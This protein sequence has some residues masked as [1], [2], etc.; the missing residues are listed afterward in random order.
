[1]SSLLQDLNQEQKT[2]VTHGNGPLLLVAG[3]GTGKTTVITKRIAWL[4]EQE[5]AKPEEILALT[6][7]DKAAGE[8][9]ERIDKLLPYGYV[10][11]WVSTFHSFCERILKAHALDIGIPNDFKLLNQV[12][13]WLVIRQNLDRFNLDYY[14][15][16]GNPTKFIHALVKHFSRAK[17]EEVTT[18]EYLSYA[19]ELKLNAGLVDGPKPKAKKKKKDGIVIDPAEAMR[20]AEVA[21][22]Y[23]VYQQV[24]LQHNALDFGDLI[25]YALKLFRTRPNILKHYQ[26]QFKYILVDEFQDT[27]YAQYELVKMLAS[28]GNIT[29]VGDDDQSIYKFRGAS[30]SN[31]LNFKK[32]YP[33][34]KEVYLTTNYRS[35]Q[36]ILDSAYRFIQLNNPNRLEAILSK[37]ANA[38]SKQLIAARKGQGIVETLPS[39]T[40][41]EETHSI[42]QKIVDLKATSQELSWSDFAI[43]VRANDTAQPFITALQANGIPYQWLAS[44]GLYLK[45][46]VLDLVSYLR[47]L[48]NYHE[49]T[50]M[51]RVLTWQVWDIPTK[52]IIQLNH[53]AY[54]KGW[55]VYEAVK[56]HRSYISVDQTVSMK[57]DNIL[58]NVEKHTQLARDKK[59]GIVFLTALQDTG[60]LKYLAD[61]ETVDNQQ[62]AREDLDYLRQFYRRIQRFEEESTVGTVKNFL[63][64]FEYEVESGEEGTLAVSAEDPSAGPDSVKVMTVHAAKGLEFKHVFLPALVDKR[65][66]TIERKDPIELPDALVKDIVPEGDVH[67]QEERRLLY[68]AMTRARDGLYLSYAKDYGGIRAKKPSRF[69]EELGL[70]EREKVGRE[71]ADELQLPLPVVTKQ[72]LASR[73]VSVRLS[74]TQLKAYENC[75]LQYKF[76]HVLKIP[77]FGKAV[78]S[79]GKTMHSTVQKFMELVNERAGTSQG[80]LFGEH[81]KTKGPAAALD[82]LF[83]IYQESWIDDW[84]ENKKTQEEYKEKGK[85]ALEMFY[86]DWLKEKPKVLFIEKGFSLKVGEY[87]IKGMMDRVDEGSDGSWT[88]VDYKTGRSKE[89]NK[90]DKDQLYIYQLAVETVF[91]GKVKGLMFYYLEDGKKL[92][93]L[94]EEKDLEKVKNYIMEMGEKI[95]Q[96]DFIPTP[97]PQVCKYCDF[98]DICEF[99]K[100]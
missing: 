8:M 66:P 18:E 39:Q 45:S 43:L 70:V 6:F 88:I 61:K 63:E 56:Q 59:A 13:Q 1:M 60:Y 89:E 25:G 72:E 46:V 21:D 12:E 24:M 76:A 11:L 26:E 34:A 27:N 58:A 96:S 42:I 38:L 4:I 3:A 79:F 57:L 41:R 80:S 32:D 82:D 90:V 69:L 50:A 37:G 30:V 94:G 33:H 86:A 62:S 7:T 93:F 53:L 74:Y 35:Y 99:K 51:Y 5:L 49:S 2:A 95:R 97:S 52:D 16:L 44:K 40:A 64:E 75:P 29:V 71:L 78:F 84:Y 9:E 65:F 100:V 85:K 23:H 68:V 15:P 17:D 91:G 31:I 92:E 87:M 54:R 22:A 83:K 36:N 98:R 28:N 73:P 67:L 81:T 14:R 47:L 48:D 55:S 10:D 20:I 19:E 77:I